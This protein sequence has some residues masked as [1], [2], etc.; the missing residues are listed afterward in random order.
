MFLQKELLFK[1]KIN[2]YIKI[3]KSLIPFVKSPYQNWTG[4][5]HLEGDWPKGFT[6]VLIGFI[7]LLEKYLIKLKCLV[8]STVY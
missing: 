3:P 7:F 8:T 1:Y 2:K 4:L 5:G 6:V